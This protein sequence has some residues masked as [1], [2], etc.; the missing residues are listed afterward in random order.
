MTFGS[1]GRSPK[2][3]QKPGA[4]HAQK[5]GIRVMWIGKKNYLTRN[6]ERNPEERREKR[7]GR[8]R[9]RKKEKEKERREG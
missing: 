1:C 4:V 7:K 3:E 6:P 8:K 2:T 5:P 9:E